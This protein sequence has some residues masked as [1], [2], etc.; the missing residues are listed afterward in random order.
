MTNMTDNVEPLYFGDMRLG[1][2][3]ERIKNELYSSCE[4]MPVP[5]VLGLLECV[6][7]EILKNM[8]MM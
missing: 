1:T 8:D 3:C 5:I 6:K 7:I 4:G 2:I